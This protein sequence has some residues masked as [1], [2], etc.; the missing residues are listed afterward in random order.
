M[1][2]IS[3]CNTEGCPQAAKCYRKTAKWDPHWQSVTPFQFNDDGSCEHFMEQPKPVTKAELLKLLDECVD[4]GNMWGA[5][6]IYGLLE[7]R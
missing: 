1:P 2:D 7:G 5:V 4:I 3:M 6:Y